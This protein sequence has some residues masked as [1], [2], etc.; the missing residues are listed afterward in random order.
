MGSA[1]CQPNRKKVKDAVLTNKTLPPKEP[2]IKPVD[3]SKR[4]GEEVEIISLKNLQDDV[5]D[6][7]NNLC[8]NSKDSDIFA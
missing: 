5:S 1:C 2:V 4:D 6:F 8:L 3:L 7:E